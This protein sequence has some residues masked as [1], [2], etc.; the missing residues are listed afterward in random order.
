MCSDDKKALYKLPIA[1]SFVPYVTNGGGVTHLPQLNDNLICGGVTP[2]PQLNDNPYK[3]LPDILPV[4]EKIVRQARF[5]TKPIALKGFGIGIYSKE[6]KDDIAHLKNLWEND[7]TLLYYTRM[8]GAA[9][10]NQ[11]MKWQPVETIES[12]Y[13]KY[14]CVPVVKQIPRLI[15]GEKRAASPPM[16]DTGGMNLIA[17]HMRHL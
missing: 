13:F 6:M 5:D 11:R 17:K 15:L 2:L 10:V 14:N 12:L 1:K 4:P 8:N 7:K 3:A 16:G 9:F